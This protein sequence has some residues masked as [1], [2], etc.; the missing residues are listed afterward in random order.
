MSETEEKQPIREKRAERRARVE[1]E[2]KKLNLQLEE[3][4]EERNELLAK[5]QRVSADYANFQKRA[6]K[7]IAES[8]AYEKEAIIKT[9]LPGLDSFNHALAEHQSA[10]NAEAVFKGMRI[11]YEQILDILKS[12]GV[13]QIQA[14]GQKFD[15]AVHQAMMQRSEPDKEDGIVLEEFQKGFKLNGRTIRPSKVIVNKLE[16]GEIPGNQGEQAGEEKAKTEQVTN[17]F[18]TTDLE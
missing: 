16:T 18:E 7:Q 5:F 4:Q 17:E 9:L 10:E 14:L 11:V 3:L 12:H 13:E 6:P 1:K 2:L 8:I 15:P